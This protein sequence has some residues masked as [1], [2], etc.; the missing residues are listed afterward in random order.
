[1]SYSLDGVQQKT[2]LAGTVTVQVM[3]PLEPPM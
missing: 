1:L 3:P 2:S